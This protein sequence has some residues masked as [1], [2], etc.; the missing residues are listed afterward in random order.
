MGTVLG[1]D[2]P[3]AMTPPA[4]EAP[5][6][7]VVPLEDKEEEAIGPDQ[8]ESPPGLPVRAEPTRSATATVAIGPQRR[9]SERLESMRR[10]RTRTATGCGLD[11]APGRECRAWA[12]FLIQALVPFFAG[13]LLVMYRYSL[14]LRAIL[15]L[16][17][18]RDLLLFTKALPLVSL[19]CWPFKR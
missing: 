4:E 19:R 7:V 15:R 2:A 16:P 17:I 8:Y 10:V 1:R 9:R 3:A 6:A 5:A 12:R 18:S 13:S 11:R 14:G